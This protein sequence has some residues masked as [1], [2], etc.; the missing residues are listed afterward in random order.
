MSKAE[1]AT[2]RLNPPF[3][4]SDFQ[5]WGSGAVD[6]SP[7]VGFSPMMPHEDAGMRSEPPPSAPSAIGTIPAARAAHAGAPRNLTT[8]TASLPHST[9]PTATEIPACAGMT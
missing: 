3:E 4:A 5:Y 1:S 7:R 9:L 2:L 6:T 8:S